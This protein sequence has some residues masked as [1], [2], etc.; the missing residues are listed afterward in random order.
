MNGAAE[1]QRY[2]AKNAMDKDE[3]GWTATNSEASPQTAE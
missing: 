2:A 3:R 1:N